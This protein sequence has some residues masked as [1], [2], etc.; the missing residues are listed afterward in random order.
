MKELIGII[1][2]YACLATIWCGLAYEII[3]GAHL[4]FILITGGA[5]AA[6]IF[7]KLRGK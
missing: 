4:G 2:Q 3:M 5:T 1:G 6:M 7:T